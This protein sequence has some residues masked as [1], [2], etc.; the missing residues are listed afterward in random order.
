[1]I[2]LELSYFAISSLT[3][4]PYCFLYWLGRS[5][6]N[7]LCKYSSKLT[8]QWEM[9]SL[10]L[11]EPRRSKMQSAKITTNTPQSCPLSCCGQ[12][13]WRRSRALGLQKHANWAYKA[14]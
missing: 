3:L 10:G 2:S 4:H 14:Y 13:T 7:L 9:S 1:M 12:W 5:A 6:L 11:V 8:T